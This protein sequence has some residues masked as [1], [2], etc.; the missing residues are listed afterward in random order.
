MSGS[1]CWAPCSP[2]ILTLAIQSW[3]LGNCSLSVLSACWCRVGCKSCLWNA[4]EYNLHSFSG[5]C[6]QLSSM[7]Q[8]V[9]EKDARFETQVR[10]HEDEL[11]QLVTQSDVE[12]EMQQV[13]CSRFVQWLSFN[14]DFTAT[15]QPPSFPTASTQPPCSPWLLI[16][17]LSFAACHFWV[18]TSLSLFPYP[19]GAWHFKAELVW[20]SMGWAVSWLLFI[21]SFAPTIH[22]LSLIQNFKLMK[23]VL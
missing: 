11:L 6:L 16:G 9:R 5:V 10:L 21:C 7:Q 14:H 4:P 2:S 15:R 3:D 23:S 22:A 13:C 8:V 12:T 19:I 17:A 20:G 18:L 1:C